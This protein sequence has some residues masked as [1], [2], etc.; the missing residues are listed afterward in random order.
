MME[1]DEWWKDEMP[2]IS[3]HQ[4]DKPPT[5]PSRHKKEDLNPQESAD[6]EGQTNSKEMVAA[7]KQEESMLIAQLNSIKKF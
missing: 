2:D 3:T 6:M 5:P 7:L 1:E 4:F